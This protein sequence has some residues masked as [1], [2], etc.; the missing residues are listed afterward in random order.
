MAH[1]AIQ[2]TINPHTHTPTSISMPTLTTTL[3]T[4]RLC[5]P[6]WYIALCDHESLHDELEFLKDTFKRNSYSDRQIRRALD[7]PKRVATTPEKPTLAALLP[8][9]NTTFNRI[10]RMLSWHS[11]KSVGLPLRKTANFLR[12]VKDDLGLKTLGVYS[13]P[14]VCGQVYIGQ[15]GCSIDTRIKEHHRHLRLAHPDKSAVAEHSI[16]RGHHIQLQ[17]TKI[18]STK[19][20]YMDRLIKEAIDIELHPNNMNREDGLCLS[21]SWKPLNHTLKARRNPP[22]QGV[23]CPICPSQDNS[24]PR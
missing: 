22:A 24:A 2:S 23:S 16:S 15:T 1:W 13:I 9:V 19:S 12:P 11:I 3:P 14:S 4:N 17:D 10:S 7:P 18:L 21:R 6:R 8:L 20:R 5:F